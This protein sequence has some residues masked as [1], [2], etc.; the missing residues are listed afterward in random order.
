MTMNRII[1]F[2]GAIVLLIAVVVIIKSRQQHPQPQMMTRLPQAAAPDAD[3]PADTVRSLSAKVAALAENT[4]RL[5]EEN[6]HLRE[7]NKTTKIQEDRVAARVRKALSSELNRSSQQDSNALSGFTAQLEQLRS[8]VSKITTDMPKTTPPG[9]MPVGFGYGDIPGA[10]IHWIEDLNA[11]QEVSG[12]ALTF[13]SATSAGSDSLLHPNRQSLDAGA[14]GRPKPQKTTLHR[15]RSKDKSAITPYYTI[16]ANATLMNSTAFSALVGR[17]P[18]GGQVQ[19]PMPI[20]VLIGADN[21]AANG[22][23][24]PGLEGIVMSGY[25][26]G[27]WTL[28]CVRGVLTSAT[29]VFG[30]GHVQTFGEQKNAQK[31]D[32]KDN[33]IGYISDRFG[34]PCVA[35]KRITNAPGFLSQRIGIMAL[36]AAAEAAAAAETTSVVD[37]TGTASSTVTGNLGKY[38]LGKSVSGGAQEIGAWL[39]ERQVQSFDAIFVGAGARITVHLDTTLPIDYDPDGR[40]LDHHARLSGTGGAYGHLDPLPRFVPVWRSWR[41]PAAPPPRRKSSPRADRTCSRF[42]PGTCAKAAPTKTL[43]SCAAASVAPC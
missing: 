30:D 15:A 6:Q 5:T 41:S 7:E 38:I 22:H 1:P 8:K 28:A 16:P 29:F 35:G 9:D 2:I 20:K 36:T 42:I 18:I 32:R 12:K 10:G 11:P 17:V 24:I 13:T 3:T 37:S 34:V 43:S 31:A 21:L 27:D 33:Q 4:R 14:S 19:D 40:M 23:T 39:S 25:A 26:V